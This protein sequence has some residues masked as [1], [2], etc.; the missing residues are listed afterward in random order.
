MSA[1]VDLICA[2]GSLVTALRILLRPG[3]SLCRRVAIHDLDRHVVVA[4]EDKKPDRIGLVNLPVCALLFERGQPPC[5]DK[6]LTDAITS[7]AIFSSLALAGQRHCG[8]ADERRHHAK[9]KQLFHVR[10]LVTRVSRLLTFE[11]SH[12]DRKAILHIGLEQSLVSFVDFLDRDDFDIGGDVV[13]PAEI[14][15]LLSFGDAADVRA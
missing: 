15:H 14:E 12:I 8:H 1:F 13:L 9:R 2:K 11:R 6:S 7:T 3:W 4:C 10:L 5:S